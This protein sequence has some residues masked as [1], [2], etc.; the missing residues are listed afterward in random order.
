V[1]IR[2]PSSPRSL[3][4]AAIVKVANGWIIMNPGAGPTPDKPDIIP[5]PGPGDPVSSFVNVPVANIAAF[6]ADAKSKGP[7]RA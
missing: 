2:Q 6:D 4:T 3:E 7:T 1:V 5:A